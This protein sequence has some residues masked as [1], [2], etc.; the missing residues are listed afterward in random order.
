[1]YILA[2]LVAA[3]GLSWAFDNKPKSQT[4]TELMALREALLQGNRTGSKAAQ[5]LT[6]EYGQLI[7]QHPELFTISKPYPLNVMETGEYVWAL[8]LTKYE[9]ARDR[10]DDDKQ[11]DL[12]T[13]TYHN[14]NNKQL[15]P[16]IF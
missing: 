5:H 3:W 13:A 8:D 12:I 6:L 14:T 11:G 9:R 4:Y 7:K 10:H 2:S 1:M 16:Y 15:K